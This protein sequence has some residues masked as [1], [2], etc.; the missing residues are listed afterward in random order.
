[1]V[2][3]S[4]DYL[5]EEGVPEVGLPPLAAPGTVAARTTVFVAADAVAL[6]A[7]DIDDP[8]KP[9]AAEAV[10]ALHDAGLTV[11]LLS[12]D[13]QAAAEAVAASVGIESVT[14]GVR[15]ADKADHVKALQAAGHV[16]GH[17]R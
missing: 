6:G 8:I 1:M 17:G 2:V 10:R 14:A 4:G 5:V 15:P 13:T 9:G 7:I 12:G 16:G 3:G 11:H